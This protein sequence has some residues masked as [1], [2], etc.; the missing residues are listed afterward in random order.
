MWEQF[1]HIIGTIDTAPGA[2][3]RAAPWIKDKGFKRPLVV[4]DSNTKAVAGEALLAALGD[5]DATQYLFTDELLVADEYAVGRLTAAYSPDRDIIVAVGSGTIGDLC[6]FIAARVGRPV[7]VVGTAPSMDGYAS[8]SSAMT[9]R[10]LK[11]TPQTK[12]P[13]AIFCDPDVLKDA[14][15]NMIAAGLGDIF[16]KIT[17]MADWRL[18]HMLSGERWD[19][20]VAALVETALQKCLDGAPLVKTRSP[21][22]IRD[23]TDALIMSGIAMSLYGD[24]R[25]A[26]G[27]EHHLSHYWEL[28]YLL[29]GKPPVLHGTKVGV[30]T[31][32]G[33][34]MWQWLPEAL[35]RPVP[36]DRAET[37]RR[38]RE[39]YGASAGDIVKTENP[40]PPF[41][42]IQ[43]RWPDILELARSLPRPGEIAALLEAL[44][45][46]SRPAGI[47]LDAGTLKD[48]VVLARE[49]KK[50]YTLLQLLGNLGLL[51]SFAERLASE[52]A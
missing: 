7:A 29:E 45:A 11:V 48:G 19:E 39:M 52:L 35:A 17:S 37:L 50:T 22:V 6:K 31:I 10:G 32:C 12:I 16:G 36:E 43:E 2:L 27:T 15:M 3:G 1:S 23:I 13:D 4:M 51:E 38:V 41:E 18:A 33:L 42:N 46:P 44:G 25:P 28:R 9:L 30:A 26:S 21:V 5:I 24:S 40:N 20:G 47:G 14:P 49:R 8:S 34:T